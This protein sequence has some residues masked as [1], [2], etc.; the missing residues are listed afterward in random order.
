MESRKNINDLK[1]QEN[2][3][4]NSSECSIPN[5]NSIPLKHSKSSGAVYTPQ[6]NL[7]IIGIFEWILISKKF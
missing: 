2:L 3:Q 6:N 1:Q 4:P 7:N 5:L